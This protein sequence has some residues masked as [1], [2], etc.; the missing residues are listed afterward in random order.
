MNEPQTI[1]LSPAIVHFE[2]LVQGDTMT[3]RITLT[4]G[5]SDPIDVTGD[6]F[7]MDIRR[8][9]NSLVLSFAIGDGIE[10]TGAGEITGTIDPA[11]TV[12]LE[13]DFTYQYDVQWTSG[14]T[15]RTIAWGQIQLLKQITT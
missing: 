4:D 15:V 12:G 14:A 11:D 8:L 10:I 7:D 9:D 2:D 5:N 13:Q 3:W 1:S 6:S